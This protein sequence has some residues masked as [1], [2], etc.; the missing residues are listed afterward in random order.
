MGE[1]VLDVT[2][3]IMRK[4][5]DPVDLDNSDALL[6]I[7]AISFSPNTVISEGTCN[8]FGTE[9]DPLAPLFVPA[10]VSDLV[11][12]PFES[13]LNLNGSLLSIDDPGGPCPF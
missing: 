12:S 11:A 9:L 13:Q 7:S 4:T 6:E 2:P 5:V 1:A 8:E 10:L 3:C